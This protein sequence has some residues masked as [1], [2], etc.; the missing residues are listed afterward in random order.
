MDLQKI[1]KELVK[2]EPKKG[3]Q[4]HVANRFVDV[5][6]GFAGRS[7]YAGK[8]FFAIISMIDFSVDYHDQDL[9]F[10]I[11]EVADAVGISRHGQ[12]RYDLV[13]AAL[14]TLNSQQIHVD[15]EGN[16]LNEEGEEVPF[17]VNGTCNWITECVLNDYTREAV[18]RLPK[19][20][21]PIVLNLRSI[22]FKG[23]IQKAFDTLAPF[24][25]HYFIHLY[26]LILEKAEYASRVGNYWKPSL[27]DLY[28]LLCLKKSYCNWQNFKS[29]ILDP[30][31]EDIANNDTIDFYME[32]EPVYAKSYGKGRKAVEAVKIWT[33]PK[34]K[35]I[36]T[37][38]KE[39]DIQKTTKDISIEDN[40]EKVA[41]FDEKTVSAEAV[42]DVE[43]V[44]K[45]KELLLQK[46]V[47]DSVADQLVEN[48]P[49]EFLLEQIADFKRKDIKSVKSNPGAFLK[50]KIENAWKQ[51]VAINSNKKVS[52][53]DRFNDML[54]EDN[55]SNGSAGSFVADSEALKA[56][57]EQRKQEK[58]QQ[59][60]K[61]QAAEEKK[62]QDKAEFDALI[63]R[64]VAL[65][66]E[67]QKERVIEIIQSEN[68]TLYQMIKKYSFDEAFAKDAFKVILSKFIYERFMEQGMID[69][70]Y[71]LLEIQK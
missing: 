68:P 62:Q 39:Q 31:S 48:Y 38:K 46:G 10:N 58:E 44:S 16:V 24:R 57:F 64:R 54:S 40:A 18:V 7:P 23:N 21:R 6:W 17:R 63:A 2:L 49:E 55:A 42:V 70:G 14:D 60:A 53:L 3:M 28:S 61:R 47:L 36:K 59:E 8:I 11:D 41:V 13:K 35:K 20:L 33:I 30:F 69:G 52:F 19:L 9:K 29:R 15:I 71:E 32:Y 51:L 56:E 1:D 45:A 4:Y 25:S 65:M 50:T 12:D 34:N 66:S 22:A 5:P 43:V 37:S 27:D 26:L 67:V